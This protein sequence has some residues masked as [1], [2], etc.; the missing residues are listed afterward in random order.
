VGESELLGDIFQPDAAPGAQVVARCGDAFQEDRVMFQPVI[1]PVIFRFETDQD[2][3]RLAVPRDDNLFVFGQMKIFG[4]LIFDF[5]QCYLFHRVP[6]L[7]Q[8]I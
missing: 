6:L 2:T 4:K 3:G 1:D 8:S 7:R 5:R